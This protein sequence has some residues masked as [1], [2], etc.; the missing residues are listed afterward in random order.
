M[1]QI[2]APQASMLPWP[3]LLALRPWPAMPGQGRALSLWGDRRICR[4]TPVQPPAHSGKHHQPA[5]H[6]PPP[7]E[8][9]CDGTSL[10]VQGLDL[11]FEGVKALAELIHG[12]V[13][14]RSWSGEG[15]KQPKKEVARV[16][17]GGMQVSIDGRFPRLNEGQREGV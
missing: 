15:G 2:P 9:P 3:D 5:G 6:A 16:Y 1:D 14:S 12:G 10:L 7:A 13:S 4:R 8:R 17:R 11:V